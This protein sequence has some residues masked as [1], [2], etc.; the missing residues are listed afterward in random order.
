MTVVSNGAINT[1]G[2]MSLGILAQSGYGGGGGK[3]GSV[4]QRRCGA[5]GRCRDAWPVRRD[6]G[7][8]SGDVSVNE[9][10]AKI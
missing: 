1:G 5:F 4:D 10:N 9:S 7:G 2:H 8:V 3:A 6:G